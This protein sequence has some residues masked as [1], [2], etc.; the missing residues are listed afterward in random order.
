M[1]K[2][3]WL[4]NKSK[5]DCIKEI[6]CRLK[7][8]EGTSLQPLDKTFS[9]MRKIVIQYFRS[10][11]EKVKTFADDWLSFDFGF[12]IQENNGLIVETKFKC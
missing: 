4:K 9:F 6:N 7:K 3:P 5:N 1:F 12:E 11:P 8:F 10:N 2:N